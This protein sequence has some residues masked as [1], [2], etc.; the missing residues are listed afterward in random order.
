M[1]VADIPQ[2]EEAK[3]RNREK[4][5]GRK[6]KREKK[7]STRRE[8]EGAGRGKERSERREATHP[9]TRSISK[10]L[11]PFLTVKVSVEAPD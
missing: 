7:V 8:K 1:R 4:K 2:L 3:R 9:V 5:K 6:R 11:A 10:K